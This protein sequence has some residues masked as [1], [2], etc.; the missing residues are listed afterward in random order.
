MTEPT[1]TTLEPVVREVDVA[2]PVETCF[3]VFVEG[4]DSWWPPQRHV[5]ADRVVERF[6]VEPVVGGRCYDIDTA[7]AVSHWGTVLGIEPPRRFVFAWHVQGD[8][9]IDRDPARQSEVE[10][11]FTPTCEETTHVR[12]VHRHIERHGLADA[13]RAGVSHP[14]G[15][16]GG[17]DRFVD[18]TEGREPRPLPS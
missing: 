1:A 8:W 13:I 18:V 5:G 12:L 6:V 16:G 11:T 14:A 2:A 10:V 7:G 17:L 3:Q 4:I 9:T 15:W